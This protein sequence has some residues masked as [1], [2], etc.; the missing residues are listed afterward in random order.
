MVEIIARMNEPSWLDRSRPHSS[1][2]TGEHLG[3]QDAGGDGVFEVVADVGDP[4]AIEQI[5]RRRVARTR[6]ALRDWRQD[7][8]RRVDLER[9]EPRVA[10]QSSDEPLGRPGHDRDGAGP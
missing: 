7:A 4:V 6:P 8:R 1:P 2:T 9:L 10:G 5:G 3:A